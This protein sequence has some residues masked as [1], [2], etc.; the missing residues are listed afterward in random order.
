MAYSNRANLFV[1]LTVGIIVLLVAVLLFG[2]FLFKRPDTYPFSD[3]YA[4]EPL[5]DLLWNVRAIDLIIQSS[6]IFAGVLGILALFR[7]EELPEIEAEAETTETVLA[8]EV[9]ERS[10]GEFFEEREKKRSE[11]CAEEDS[12]KNAKEDVKEEE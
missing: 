7:P 10:V 5:R 2:M 11:E 3:T 6:L 4:V 8:A 12:E 9:E 1:G